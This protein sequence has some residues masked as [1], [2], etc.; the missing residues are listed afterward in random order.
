M[1]TE[2]PSDEWLKRKAAKARTLKKQGLLPAQVDQ[3]LQKLLGWTY[4]LKMWRDDQ[5]LQELAQYYSAHKRMPKIRDPDPKNKKLANF[6]LRL[7]KVWREGS[8]TAELITKINA[9][10][11]QLIQILENA[12]NNP[13]K[14]RSNLPKAEKKKALLLMALNGESR[15]KQG[16][17]FGKCCWHYRKNDQEFMQV[18]K[19]LESQALISP[20]W[21]V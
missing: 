19:L 9:L 21:V 3:E 1:T 14:K 12:K 15:P 17:E 20:D 2:K 16:H 10:H 18:L 6:Y 5:N 4:E 8:Q 11:P 13:K 7:L